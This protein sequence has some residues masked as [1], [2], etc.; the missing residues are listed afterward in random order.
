MAK[1]GLISGIL[2]IILGYVMLYVIGTMHLI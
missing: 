1:I 2:S